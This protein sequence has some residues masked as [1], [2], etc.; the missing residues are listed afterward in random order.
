MVVT[1]RP[2]VSPFGG[3]FPVQHQ[4]RA[5]PWPPAS[6]RCSS[7][8]HPPRPCYVRCSPPVDLPRY[9]DAHG[10]MFDAH[11]NALGHLL[12]FITNLVAPADLAR[13]VSVFSLAFP[14]LLFIS[15]Q[16]SRSFY[17]QPLP[18]SAACFHGDGTNRKR[19][20]EAIWMEE[21]RRNHPSN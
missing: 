15:L 8:N 6:R 21:P 9:C 10:H 2:E 1:I 11:G 18:L 16:I 17:T 14:T 5:A 7:P 19:R 4:H 3:S 13:F 20:Q 12:H